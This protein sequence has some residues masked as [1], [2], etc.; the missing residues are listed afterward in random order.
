MAKKKDRARYGDYCE[1]IN[2]E[3]YGVVNIPVGNGKYRKKR[4]KVSTKTDARLWALEQLELARHGS[5]EEKEFVTFLDLAAW[6][7]KYFLTEPVFENG[8]KVQGVKDW[9]RQKAKLDCIAA[10]FGP[11]RLAHFGETNLRAYAHERRT[12]DKVTTATLNRDFALMRAMFR[13][14]H[15]E[16]PSVKIPHFPINT[17]AEV[18]R[19]RVLTRDEETRLLAACEAVES[20]D[21]EKK[22]K[23]VHTDKHRTNRGH[24]KAIII[25]A[26]DTAMRAGE[27]FS[28]TWDNVDLKTGIITI[29]AQHSKTGQGRKV[30]M[31]PRVKAELDKLKGKGTIFNYRSVRQAFSTACDRAKIK[32]L[33]FHDLRHTATTRM[34]RAGIPHTE[35]MKI[36]GHTQLKT[37]LRYLNLVDESVQ[38]TASMLADYLDSTP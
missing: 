12:K 37:F 2:G 36:T 22:G 32:D 35:V 20:L 7:S 29:R 38:N 5:P 30:G 33:H 23:Q 8:M 26:V 11:K 4:K 24:L 31:T 25:V 3:L 15:A 19:D 1:V 21:Y 34:I 13:K 9:K 14:G 17:K 10:Y 6:Y 28:L 27:I 18:E 16:N